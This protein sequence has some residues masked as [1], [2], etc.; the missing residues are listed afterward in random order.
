M[1]A[2]SPMEQAAIMA[3]VLFV[4]AG[5]GVGVV[6]IDVVAIVLLVI[7][8]VLLVSTTMETSTSNVV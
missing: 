2:R 1:V 7:D 6:V 5:D 3:T 8:D 4:V